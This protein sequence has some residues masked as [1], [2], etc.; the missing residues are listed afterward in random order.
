MSIPA[1][2]VVVI[3]RHGDLRETL[4]A[5]LAQG[6]T[7][8][9]ELVLVAADVE[10][11]RRAYPELAAFETV[12]VVAGAAAP[13]SSMAIAAG[14]RA[15]RG[16]VVAYCEDHV[17]PEPGWVQARLDAHAAGAAVVGGTLRNANPATAVSWASFLQSFGPF[18]MPVAGGRSANLPWHQCS[19][20]RDV[21]PLGSELEALLETEGLLHGDLLEAGHTLVLE[22]AAVAGHINPSRL[23]SHMIHAWVGGRVWGAGRARHARWSRARRACNALLCPW[24]ALMALRLRMADVQRVMPSRR[25][26][27]A[28]AM[29]AGIAVHAVGEAIGVL[30]GHGGATILRTDLELNRRAHLADGDLPGR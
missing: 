13:T 7:A 21:L 11:A 28:A 29:A 26:S 30:L 14:V 18:A 25:R 24:N 6:T 23:S 22:A 12:N 17:F 8:G 2:S 4:G 19:Y 20:R 16:A 10:A 9:V 1:M 5:L 3:D 27:I 15:S